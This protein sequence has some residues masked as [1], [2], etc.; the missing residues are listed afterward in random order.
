MFR[1]ALVADRLQLEFST[2]RKVE[3]DANDSSL[4]CGV[5]EKYI[6][7]TKAGFLE[8]TLLSADNGD[9][10]TGAVLKQLLLRVPI[11][12]GG[13]QMT[14]LS[15]DA[16]EEWVPAVVADVQRDVRVVRGL[17]RILIDVNKLLE[18]NFT[19]FSALK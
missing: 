15:T 19:V 5:I 4:T 13:G 17:L 8:S 10:I 1:A 11:Y 14:M 6:E 18:N 7:T 2:I 12:W 9:T 16:Y 3:G